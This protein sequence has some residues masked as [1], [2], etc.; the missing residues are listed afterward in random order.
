VKGQG[1]E[2]Q[3]NNGSW[4]NRAFRR[5]GM[6]LPS[7]LR[8]WLMS[9]GPPAQPRLRGADDPKSA[10]LIASGVVGFSQR[11]TPAKRAGTVRAS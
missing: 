8:P 11:F 1:L 9:P 3:E 5:I 7:G 4:I 2:A 6:S 10:L